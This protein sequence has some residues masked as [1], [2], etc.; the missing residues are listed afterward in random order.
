MRSVSKAIATLAAA[1]MAIG[2]TTA[3]ATTSAQPVAAQASQPSPWL[4]LSAMSSTRAIALG[5]ATTAAQPASEPVPPPPPAYAGGGVAVGAEL[6]PIV[7]WFGLI[8]IALTLGDHER[9]ANSP[10]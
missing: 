10:S 2:S 4:I 7:G 9:R 8:V 3:A 6:I 1:S 5:G